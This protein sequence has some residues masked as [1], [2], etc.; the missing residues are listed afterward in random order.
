MPQSDP[1]PSPA[2]DEHPLTKE[3]NNLPQIVAPAVQF[4]GDRMA[5]ALNEQQREIARLKAERWTPVGDN[6]HNAVLCDVGG[7]AGKVSALPFPPPSNKPL[8]HV[9]I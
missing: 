8:A 5:A 7:S 9:R 6:H 1:A 2:A 4:C 3:W